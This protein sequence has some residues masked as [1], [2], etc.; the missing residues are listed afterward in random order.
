M[1]L[2][3]T[4]KLALVTGSTAGIGFA[5]AQAL[6]AAGVIVGIN[7]RSMAR[8]SH[9][10]QVI[11][12]TYP[13]AQLIPIV[14]D[15]TQTADFEI[16]TNTM[17]EL[18]ILINNFGLYEAK[19]FARLEDTDWLK[20]F[21]ANVLSGAKLSQYYLPRM[22]QRNSG[23]I[24]FISSESAIHVPTEMLHYGVSKASQ[25]AVARGLA[26]LTVGSKVTV[27][28]ILPGPTRTE[29]VEK[30]LQQLMQQNQQSA[31]QVEKDFFVRTRPGSLL[32]RFIEPE[33]VASACV[34]LVSPLAAAINGSAIRVDG[35]LVHALC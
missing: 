7:G 14:A 8:V 5:I 17:P 27:N 3:L 10:M 4:G 22:L 9:A 31:E 28:S 6:A 26:E 18:D 23:R 15:L 34:Y 35:G 32:Q 16:V 24:I 12:T 20:L 2:N 33:E 25:L 29:G 13:Q 21:T 11:K 30:F 19:D 1:Q